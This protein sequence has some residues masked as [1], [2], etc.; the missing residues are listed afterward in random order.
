MM[1]C[2]ETRTKFYQ[3]VKFAKNG[4]ELRRIGKSDDALIE[5]QKCVVT[6]NEVHGGENNENTAFVF[7]M[8]GNVLCDKAQY[9]E[10]LVKQR[11][12][13]D[14]YRQVHGEN[15][16][17]TA[18]IYESI[19]NVLSQQGLYDE[20]IIG[21]GKALTIRIKCHGE[22]HI[23]SINSYT[24]IASVLE[25][26][27]QLDEALVHYNKAFAICQSEI[28]KVHYQKYVEIVAEICRNR[29]E[30][31]L[32]GM[33][34][35]NTQGND[36]LLAE[37]RKAHLIFK[38]LLPSEEDCHDDNR[39]K[40]FLENRMCLEEEFS[41]IEKKLEVLGRKKEEKEGFKSEIATKCSGVLS[42]GKQNTTN[43]DNGDQS[44]IKTKNQ[45]HHII[46]PTRIR[47]PPI[48]R[49]H[50]SGASLSAID[51]K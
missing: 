49:M 31:A 16:K 48:A 41:L 24:C 29:G 43:N 11:Q 45:A 42:P 17:Y 27:G 1:V 9:E 36:D 15:H 8:I 35:T 40:V 25:K 7:N 3:A 5:F 51:D 26:K 2:P 12:A 32:I 18:A 19:G 13:L 22:H 28:D 44:E 37:F 39:A 34:L 10:A 47:E 14:I 33:V 4:L 38:R 30:K 23:E 6:F 50:E 46:L 20:A 21:Y